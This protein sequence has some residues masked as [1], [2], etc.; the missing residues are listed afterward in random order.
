MNEKEIVL[1][2]GWYLVVDGFNTYEVRR[3][4]K[5]VRGI[6]EGDMLRSAAK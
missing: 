5:R 2:T 4:S 6:S 1:K 3:S